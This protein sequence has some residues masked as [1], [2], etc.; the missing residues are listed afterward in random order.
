MDQRMN[1]EQDAGQALQQ[2]HP[3][4]AAQDMGA[5]VEEDVA[6]LVRSAALGQ[7]L[8]QNDARE[9]Q[10]R[11]QRAAHVRRDADHGEAFDGQ[12]LGDLR[13]LRGPALAIERTQ[14]APK[15]AHPQPPVKQADA[16]I[17]GA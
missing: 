8:G 2:T 10:P 11:R 5:L 16:Q 15:P 12:H 9:K 14:A 3:G 4:I 7:R 13:Q 1:P 6:E 17:D